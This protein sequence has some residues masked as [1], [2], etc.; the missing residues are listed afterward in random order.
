MQYPE[1]CFSRVAAAEQRQCI[2][3]LSVTVVCVCSGGGGN[4]VLSSSLV[5]YTTVLGAVAPMVHHGYGFFYRIRDDRWAHETGFHWPEN[6]CVGFWWTCA[7]YVRFAISV[8]FIKSKLRMYTLT[9]HFIRYTL[10]ILCCTQVYL[11]NCLNSSW[12]TQQGS[13]N[14]PLRFSVAVF[15]SPLL[16]FLGLWSPCQRGNP[17]MRLMLHH[18]SVA[19]VAACMRCST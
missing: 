6:L 16:F 2:R 7:A 8:E 3:F 13:G 14:I 11:H 5:G 19:S 9:G 4:F 12:Q 18:C 17:A 10:Q 1:I 15:R